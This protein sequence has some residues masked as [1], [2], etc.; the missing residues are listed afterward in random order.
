[1][2]GDGDIDQIYS[3]GARSFSIWDATTGSLVWDSGDMIERITAESLPNNFNST[4]DENDSFKNRS[5]DKG[6]EPEAIELVEMGGNIFALVGLERVGGV[7]VFDITN[8]TSPAFS[9]YTNNRDFSVTD[10]V[11]DLD[12]VGD[13]GVEDILFI[14]ASQSP[15]EAP[16]VVTANE[17]SGTV[18][19]FSVNDPF[20]AADFSLRIVHNNDGESKLLP[21]EIDGKIVGGAAEFK[22]VADQI[23][24]S[25]DKPSITLSSGDNFLASTNFD[26]SLALPP[27]QP[28]YDAVIMDSIGYDAVA[29][30]NHDFDFGPDVLERFI[31]SYQ[32]SMP[33]YLSANLDFSGESGLQELVDAG[34]IAPRTIVNVGGEQVGVIGLI[35][36]RVASIT[37]PRNVTVSMEAYETIVATQV[38]SLKA[39]GVNKII[40]IS[41]L[42]S[43]QREIELAGNI[44]D[45]DVIIA[46]GG[47][48]LLTN[49]PSIALQGSEIFGEYPLT[50]E[51]AEGKNTYIVTTPGEYK[52]IGNLEL[53]FDESGEIIAVG[54]ASNPIL[55]ADV[56][57]DS[58]LK[59]IQDSVEAYG[60]SLATILVAFTEVAMDGTRPAKRR[61]ETDQGNLIADSYLWLVGKNAPDLEPNSPVIAVQNSGG[62]RLDEVIPANSEITVKTVKDIMSFSN[63]MVLMEPLSPQLFRFSTFA[64]LDTQTYH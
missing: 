7:M 2:D 9:S 33:P 56:A 50:V 62:L 18:S 34:R 10:L 28:Y 52:Y 27:D 57:P 17:V 15:T 24:N 12:L 60:A 16:M 43:I 58:T 55:V 22:T 30:G 39:E 20:V 3:Y 29:I 13:L 47:D 35:Y 26:A 42:Q 5:D 14:E 4:N 64:C 31:E 1:M 41:H 32:V 21:T 61:F 23:R 46:R 54:A 38:D 40:L 8:P 49:D 25:D 19:L 6:P 51:N 48:E 63:D 53:A 36:D 45:V 44:A 37:S 11:A 59:V